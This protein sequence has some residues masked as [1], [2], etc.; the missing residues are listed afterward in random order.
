[1]STKK[2]HTTRYSSN[3]TVSTS[4]IDFSNMNRLDKCRFSS[5]QKF[6]KYNALQTRERSCCNTV[7]N[8]NT[9]Q[10]SQ[11]INNNN[12]NVI[13]NNF[14]K[15]ENWENQSVSSYLKN[16][17]GTQSPVYKEDTIFYNSSVRVSTPTRQPTQ[18][19]QR[20][21][22]PQS[23]SNSSVNVQY[24][25]WRKRRQ[26]PKDIYKR[27]FGLMERFSSRSHLLRIS[28]PLSLPKNNLYPYLSHSMWLLFCEKAQKE[29]TYL[30]KLEFWKVIHLDIRKVL[31]KY[32]LFMVGSTM[33]GL[34][35]ET[36][37]I[38]M[39][40]VVRQRLDDFR[41]DE[42]NNLQSIQA[43][44][45]YFDYVKSPEIIFAKVPILRFKDVRYGFEVDLNCNNDVGI[46]NTHLLH[47]YAHMDW[48]VRPLVIVVK[49]WARIN[50][51][52]DAKRMTIS[53]YSLAL[54]VIHYLQH[55][56]SPPVLPC[57]HALYPEKFLSTSKINTIDIQED[58]PAYTSANKQ[59]LGELLLGFLH[60]YANFDY[61][62]YVISVRERGVLLKEECRHV[63]APKNDSLQWKLLC[64]EE[65]FD[66]TN[67]A[68]SVYNVETFEYIKIVFRVSSKVLENS[69]ELNQILLKVKSDYHR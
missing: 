13:N 43:A 28:E 26:H 19:H 29:E 31:H 23:N 69:L 52:N 1:M 68:R 21:Y 62:K 42:L 34:G 15:E 24:S 3:S 49:H 51:I 17:N 8:L 32:S 25:P 59:S 67:T 47:C 9:L 40:L 66:M 10:G 45:R 27:V 41:N 50:D 54:M 63:C 30:Q 14:F 20:E 57:L 56:V 22:S 64:I 58:V 36:S 33:N 35:M 12:S 65:P 39:C 6:N 37:D 44:L 38:D 2:R 7:I 5:N 18:Q 4:P 60:Y 53:S 46:R 16:E 61:N 48:R 11:H 55:G